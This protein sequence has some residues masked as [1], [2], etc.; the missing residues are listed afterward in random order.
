MFFNVFTTDGFLLSWGDLAPRHFF[1]QA[2][3]MD[4]FNI[5]QNIGYI[6]QFSEQNKNEKYKQ[7]NKPL[8]FF[9]LVLFWKLFKI[10]YRLGI[11]FIIFVHYNISLYLQVLYMKVIM[12]FVLICV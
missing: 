10:A 12:W 5:F 11:V 4:I 2:E 3:Q 7:L 6:E 9:I 8:I 1:F